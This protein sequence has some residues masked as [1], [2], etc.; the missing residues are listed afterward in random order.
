[1]ASADISGRKRIQ[2]VGQILWKLK[3]VLRARAAPIVRQKL[4]MFLADRNGLGNILTTLFPIRLQ[5][6]DQLNF[7]SYPA[8]CDCI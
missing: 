6:Y 4:A 5:L 2:G 3:S 1:M 7:V 8:V